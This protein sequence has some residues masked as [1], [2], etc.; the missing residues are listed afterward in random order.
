MKNTFATIGVC[1]VLMWLGSKLGA[2]NFNLVFT[3]NPTTCF[4]WVQE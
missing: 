1:V 4:I 3:K 2:W